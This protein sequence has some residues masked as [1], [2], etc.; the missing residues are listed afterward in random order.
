MT[1]RY[2]VA[3]H[4]GAGSPEALSDGCRAACEAAAALLE[5]GGPALDAAAEAVRVLEDDGKFNAGSGSVLRLD[6]R[7]IEM[8]AAVMDARNALGVVIAIRDVRNPV[9]VAREVVGTP[10]VALAGRGATAFARM[11][12]FGP[13]HDVSPRAREHHA[14]LKELI[15]E[16]SLG[17]ENPLWQGRDIASLWNSEELSYADFFSADTVG[18]VTLDTEGNMAVAAST[19]GASPMMVGRVGDTPMIGCGF[20]AG[21]ACAVAATGLG[22]EIVKRMLAR[23]VCDMVARGEDLRTACRKGID[24][25]P[26]EIPV[27]IIGISAG[28]CE[29]IANREM[30]HH[31][32][33]QEK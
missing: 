12:G 13:F 15:R 14:R 23:T 32:L 10:H 19:G 20:Y 9:L 5:A 33:I 24:L 3:A 8:D 25:F 18:A 16:G 31:V 26:R 22:E 1:I 28:G 7:T 29:V 27:G 4:G 2:G 17:R 21:T 6:G 30:A 11:R